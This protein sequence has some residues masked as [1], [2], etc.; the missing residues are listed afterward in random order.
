MSPNYV[1]Y[2]PSLWV[3]CYEVEAKS[4]RD[5]IEKIRTYREA[6]PDVHSSMSAEYERELTPKEWPWH[7]KLEKKRT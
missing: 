1:V 2:V 6:S 5:A 3:T 7:A 4:K